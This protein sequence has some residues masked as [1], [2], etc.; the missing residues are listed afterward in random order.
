MTPPGADPEATLEVARQ[1]L[2]NPPGA[3]ASP[4]AAEQCCH[5]VNQLIIAVINTTPSEGRQVNHP[6]GAPVPSV[7]HSRSP[8]APRV[9][10]A[11]HVLAAS[12]ATVD[13]RAELE[14]RR[15]GED[16]RIT[17]ERRRE[18]CHNLDGDFR[19]VDTAPM[20]QAAR[21]PTFPTGSGGGCM[22]LAPCH[23]M[24]IWP[25]KFQPHLPEK[26]DWSVNPAEFL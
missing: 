1:L 18:R 16:G 10:S 5:D 19:V 15:S 12:L 2:H 26:Y 13:L 8:M 9:S 25:C 3:H 4:S 17:I 21:T 14:R 22:A 23:C 6:G 24:V 7:A 20:R 11:M